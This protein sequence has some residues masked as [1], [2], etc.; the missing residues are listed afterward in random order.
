M[1]IVGIDQGY[2]QVEN[3]KQNQRYGEQGIG[4][5]RLPER[6]A[7]AEGNASNEELIHRYQVDCRV[8]KALLIIISIRI[9]NELFIEF[10]VLDPEE[11]EDLKAEL[12]QGLAYD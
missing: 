5:K 12:D 8:F 10:L 7:N 9:I 1:L 3:Q 11:D 6:L 4:I 2:A